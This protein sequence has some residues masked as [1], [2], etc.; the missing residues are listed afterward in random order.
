[1]ISSVFA[2]KIICHDEANLVR[3]WPGQRRFFVIDNGKS[4]RAE[5]WL[6]YFFENLHKVNIVKFIDYINNHFHSK[7]IF[8]LVVQISGNSPIPLRSDDGPVSQ[9]GVEPE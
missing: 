1:M 7:C 6:I 4:C 8:F 5:N 3:F 9:D 2:F